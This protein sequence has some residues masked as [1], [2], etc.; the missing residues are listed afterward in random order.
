[1]ETLVRLAEAIADYDPKLMS[2]ADAARW[3]V[4]KESTK[5]KRVLALAEQIG[6]KQGA[7]TASVI[8]LLLGAFI[9]SM[10]YLR[11]V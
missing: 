9:W 1:M 3:A 6:F 2:P 10:W 4:R 11:L 5:E 7:K 8:W